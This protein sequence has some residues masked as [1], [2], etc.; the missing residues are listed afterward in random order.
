MIATDVMAIQLVILFS[1][2]L[3]IL[4]YAFPLIIELDDEVKTLKFIKRLFRLTWIWLFLFI[5]SSLLYI[6]V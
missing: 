1:Y 2:F 3:L 4:I 5:G 6:F